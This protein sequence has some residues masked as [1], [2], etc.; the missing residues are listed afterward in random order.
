VQANLCFKLKKIL[1]EKIRKI[2]K[3]V[4]Q[5]E[6]KNPKTMSKLQNLY[7][8]KCCLVKNYFCKIHATV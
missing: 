5:H 7:I 2:M 3:I 4:S 1:M 6:Y 8:L